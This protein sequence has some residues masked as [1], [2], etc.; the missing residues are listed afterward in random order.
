MN[1]SDS[2]PYTMGADLRPGDTIAFQ[3]PGGPLVHHIVTEI[4]RQSGIYN[5]APQP[6]LRTRILRKLTPPR[7]RK[8]LPMGT[9]EPD[10]VQLTTVPVPTSGDPSPTSG[11]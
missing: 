6:P 9:R 2:K 11:T 7:W 3:V 10:S 1:V 8:P 5:P 4:H